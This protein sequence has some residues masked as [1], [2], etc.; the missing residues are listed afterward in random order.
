[1]FFVMATD[2]SN[3]REGGGIIVYSKVNK[4]RA[5][6][7]TDKIHVKEIVSSFSNKF[8]HFLFL[9]EEIRRINIIHL[10]ID[11]LGL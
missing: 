9:P 5:K 3:F 6:F 8:V 11:N 10:L 1:M 2:K 4:L 7:A